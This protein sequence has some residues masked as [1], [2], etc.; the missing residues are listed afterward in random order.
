MINMKAVAVLPARMG[1]TRF[2]GKPLAQIFGRPMIEHCYRRVRMARGLSEVIVATCDQEIFDAVRAFG[3]ES[4]MTSPKHQRAS[5][6]VAEAAEKLDADLVV[7]VQGDEPMVTPAMVEAAIHPFEKNVNLRCVNLAQKILT[8]AEFQDPNTI[9]VVMD[10]NWDALY[11]SREP[12]P[13]RRIKPFGNIPAYKQV[14]IIPFRR[15]M[16][17]QY[18]QLDPTPLEIAESV[19]MMRLIEHGFKV[20]IVE[21]SERTHAVDTLDDLR[22]VEMLMEEDPFV[23]EY[24]T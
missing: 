9:K 21:T 22:S 7:M 1:S 2:P 15:D 16:L 20:R 6:R 18:T 14:C 8:E 3:G 17:L 4:V 11:F 24:L 19:D 13:T 23:R 10:G 12:I 5:D